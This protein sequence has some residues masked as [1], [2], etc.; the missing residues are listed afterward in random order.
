MPESAAPSDNR[1]NAGQSYVVFG[2]QEGFA[3]T[4]SLEDL[5]GR[6]GFVLNGLFGGDNAGSTVSGAGDVNGDGL[7]DLLIGAPNADPN[8]KERSGQTYVVFGNVAP[9][10]DLNGDGIGRDRAAVNAD[11]TN[12]TSLILNAD[13]LLI[14]DNDSLLSQ[15]LVTQVN[16]LDGTAERLIAKTEGT[17]VEATYDALN[18]QLVLSGQDSLANYRQV[19][20]QVTYEHLGETPTFGTRQF[21]FVLDDGNGFNN[22]SVGA[23]A[24]L[25]VI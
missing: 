9:E 2:R 15:V 20:G 1:P 23:I 17:N 25:T 11:L 13:D 10:I 19:L 7:F 18:Q 5:N 6:N 14:S 16:P 21:E 12:G 8:K 24:A 22:T 3:A 4:L